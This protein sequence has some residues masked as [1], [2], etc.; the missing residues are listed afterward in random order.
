MK[1]TKKKKE[2]ERKSLMEEPKLEVCAYH[3]IAGMMSIRK[4]PAYLQTIINLLI[5]LSYNTY[6]I[7]LFQ[8]HNVNPTTNKTTK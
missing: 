1:I 7:V 2:K 8:N 6:N 3:W 4:H 5:A